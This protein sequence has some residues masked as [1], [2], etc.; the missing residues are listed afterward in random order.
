MKKLISLMVAIVCAIIVGVGITP[1]SGQ[2]II[3]VYMS[4]GPDTGQSGQAQFLT[5]MMEGMKNPSSDQGVFL[6]NGAIINASQILSFP[7]KTGSKLY[8]GLSV[9]SPTIFNLNQVSCKVGDAF[10]TTSNQLISLFGPDRIGIDPYGEIYNS[11]GSADGISVTRFIGVVNSFKITAANIADAQRALDSYVRTYGTTVRYS[12]EYSLNGLVGQGS[13][14]ITPVPAPTTWL[15]LSYT[16]GQFRIY[17]A[18]V[19]N[20][21]C[22]VQVNTNLSTSNWVSLATNPVPFIFTNSVSTNEAEKYFRAIYR[23]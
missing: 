4:I 13:V 5:R 7:D 3:K 22:I 15:Q 10:F 19:T 21:N 12:A 17:V 18:G 16:N 1:V 11:P 14:I 2:G 6:M 9:D 23:P 20:W 8:I